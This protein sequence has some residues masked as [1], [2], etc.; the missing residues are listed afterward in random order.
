MYSHEARVVVDSDALIARRWGQ[1]SGEFGV[2]FIPKDPASVDS[3]A[4]RTSLGGIRTGDRGNTRPTVAPVLKGFA[5]LLHPVRSRQA[6]LTLVS[7]VCNALDQSGFEG[8]LRLG[9]DLLKKW[10]LTDI[11]PAFTAVACVSSAVLPMSEPPDYVLRPPES[12]LW[13]TESSAFKSLA[14]HA[15]ALAR[16][17]GDGRCVVASGM[18]SAYCRPDQVG[19]FLTAACSTI[20]EALLEIP[21]RDG[22][23]IRCVFGLDG[24][25]LV[26][27]TID[28]RPWATAL[29]AS[30]GILRRL[31]P[32][33]D[34]GLI[35]RSD[36]LAGSLGE[37][38]D[39]GR[40][41]PQNL[42][43][44][45]ADSHLV[46]KEAVP[47]IF[48]VQLFGPQHQTLLPSDNWDVADLP[49]GRKLVSSKRLEDWYGDD[50]PVESVQQ[51]AREANTA[52]LYFFERWLERN[53][54]AHAH[55]K[56]T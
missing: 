10:R 48:G 19:A 47:D 53:L 33:V 52:V 17:D 45:Y 44:T 20:G 21:T 9:E 15:E 46:L 55:H 23:W 2:L 40:S 54:R 1:Y 3:D 26:S 37:A 38:V 28:D 13:Q 16:S 27:E 22:R 14:N 30:I 25:F 7:E 5:I 31:A 8:V 49:A 24:Y 36:F 41:R 6:L 39:Y 43:R 29:S 35:R 18:L 11:V 32:V 56:T 12:G 42:L 34:Y 51:H 4:I 50:L